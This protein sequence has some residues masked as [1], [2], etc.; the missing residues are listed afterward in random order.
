MSETEAAEWVS[1]DSRINP[2]LETDTNVQAIKSSEKETWQHE[3]I[4][5][6]A[7]KPNFDP[8]GTVKYILSVPSYSDRPLVAIK[9]FEWHLAQV[10]EKTPKQFLDGIGF[11]PMTGKSI[12]LWRRRMIEAFVSEKVAKSNNV[13]SVHDNGEGETVDSIKVDKAE[14]EDYIAQEERY[15]TTVR[16]TLTEAGVDFEVFEYDNDLSSPE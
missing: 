7:Q 1:L 4:G 2:G 12:V 6:L 9:L 8:F 15:Y 10:L 5:K 13:W 16:H 11:N 14:L 3:A